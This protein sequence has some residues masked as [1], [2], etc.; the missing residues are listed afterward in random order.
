M[1]VDIA[2]ITYLDLVTKDG[3][4]LIAIDASAS[5]RSELGE[6]FVDPKSETQI[7]AD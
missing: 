6:S 2:L 7:A 3:F 4:G 1:T 5:L